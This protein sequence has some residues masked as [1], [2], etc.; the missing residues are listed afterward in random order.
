MLIIFQ[1]VRSPVSAGASIFQLCRILR[2]RGAISRRLKLT[3]FGLT[4]SPLSQARR[5]DGLHRVSPV[6]FRGSSFTSSLHPPDATPQRLIVCLYRL[7]GF[8][9]ISSW[10]FVA[11][12]H[13]RLR[14]DVSRLSHSSRQ[15]CSSIFTGNR[16]GI[17][18]RQVEDH[19]GHIVKSVAHDRSLRFVLE[20]PACTECDFIFRERS[21]ITR[22]SRCPKCR[23][24]AISEPRYSIERKAAR[25]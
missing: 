8:P 6:P 7:W 11:H 1:L 17:S 23:S 15:R 16:V 24:E 4:L 12:E 22:P 21:R 20:P 19:L 2:D 25:K 13:R 9:P 14:E 10:R 3:S 5:L 18:E